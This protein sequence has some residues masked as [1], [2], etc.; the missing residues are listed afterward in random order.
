MMLSPTESHEPCRM[1]RKSLLI[2]G[3]AV[4]LL[5]A[6][7]SFSFSRDD[8]DL[9][10]SC[11]RP[12]MGFAFYPGAVISNDPQRFIATYGQDADLMLLH[13]GDKVPWSALRACADLDACDADADLKATMDQLA[14]HARDFPGKV[15]VSISPLN[16]GRDGIATD[17][18]GTPAPAR[19]FADEA[20][21]EGYRR[22]AAFVQKKLSPDSFSQGI[23]INMYAAA[24]PDDFG[25]LIS[26][27][28]DIRSSA[29]PTIQWEFYK[30]AWLH[31]DREMMESMVAQWGELGDGFAFSTYPEIRDVPEGYGFQG[32]GIPVG[33]APIF[34]A[35]S[36]IRSDEQGR[37]IG[38][39]LSIPNVKSIAW[40]FKENDNALLARLPDRY[41]YSVFKDAG[42][43][44]EAWHA[45]FTCEGK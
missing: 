22:W 18:D 31:G 34:I 1:N 27:L 3:S 13:F 28:K 36:G 7:A 2:A 44:T 19:T 12:A 14:V 26:L 42:L 9:P 5:V 35:E 30:D 6:V 4:A 25:N 39:L 45:A 16:N 20:I 11:G 32:Y 24:A 38:S 41:P 17:W 43:Q 37:L 33:D 40:F 15:H 23:E 8:R 21:R 29:G 10:L